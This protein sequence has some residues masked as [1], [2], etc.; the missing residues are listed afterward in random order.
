MLV[1]SPYPSPAHPVIPDLYPTEPLAL[2]QS[3]ELVHNSP[4]HTNSNHSDQNSDEWILG[5]WPSQ[6]SSSNLSDHQTS[7]PSRMPHQETRPPL[8]RGAGSSVMNATHVY[9]GG[10]HNP[11][12]YPQ[13]PP[14][15]TWVG[16]VPLPSQ[17]PPMGSPYMQTGYV[18]GYAQSPYIGSTGHPGTPYQGHIQ[19]P[20]P[21]MA[22][23]GMGSTGSWAGAL[24]PAGAMA[25]YQQPQVAKLAR[26]KEEEI[27]AIDRWEPGPDC[28]SFPGRPSTIIISRS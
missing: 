26:P 27:I 28:K 23:P 1:P 5:P 9:H 22:I 19:Q 14:G 2:S 7:Q 24:V 6:R 13:A 17:Q 25:P 18:P 15:T 12:N 3:V 16:S 20:P 8:Q 11:F 4:A 21:S 10:A